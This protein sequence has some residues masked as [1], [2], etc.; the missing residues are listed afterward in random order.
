MASERLCSL[1][2]PQV[3][4]RRSS[5]YPLNRHSFFRNSTSLRRCP[6]EERVLQVDLEDIDSD[7]MTFVRMFP[8]TTQQME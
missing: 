6:G 8:G 4:L 5:G 2:R 1:A 7:L 3:R